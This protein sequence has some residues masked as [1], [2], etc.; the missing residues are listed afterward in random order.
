VRVVGGMELGPE[1]ARRAARLRGL[2]STTALARSLVGAAE[3]WAHPPLSS[4]RVGAVAIGAS[5][6]LYCGANLEFPP[7]PINGDTVHAEQAAAAL[8]F[9]R[10]EKRLVRSMQIRSLVAWGCCC[11]CCCMRAYMTTASVLKFCGRWRW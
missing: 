9:V 11:C 10:G 1:Q 6:A 4:Y 3:A 8:A 2:P 7:L 5:G